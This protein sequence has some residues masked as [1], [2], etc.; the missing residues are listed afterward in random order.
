MT[1]TE[2]GRLLSGRALDVCRHLLPGGHEIKSEWRCGNALGSAGDSLHVHLKGSRAG[3]WRDFAGT[4]DD[5]GD[6][7]G[8]WKQA[9]G[10]G[11]REACREARAF[12]GLPDEEGDNDFVA[13]SVPIP[14]QAVET[15]EPSKSWLRL[16]VNLRRGTITELSTLADLRKIPTLAGL[17]LATAAGQLWFADVFDD[18]FDWPAW[19][20]TDGSRRNAQARRMDGQPWSGIGGKKAKTIAGSEANWPIG[21]PEVGDRDVALVEGG[22]DFLAAWHFIWIKSEQ[23]TIAPVAILGASNAIHA[24]ALPLFRGKIVWIFP[25]VDDNRAGAIGAANWRDQLL[26]AGAAQ[27]TN[28]IFGPGE[29]KDLND[30]IAAEP[31]EDET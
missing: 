29:G 9:R 6:L 30:L 5:K 19:I 26:H 21:I 18:G 10:V 23:R 7:I 22:P 24:D 2:I 4:G 17:E 3:M 16:Q 25:H 13:P 1:A 15:R 28:Y 27:V 12:L 20:I 31:M 14:T 8:L 11:L